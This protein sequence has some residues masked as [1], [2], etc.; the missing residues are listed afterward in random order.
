MTDSLGLNRETGGTITDWEHVVQSIRDLFSTP[1][2]TRV[3]R[4][5]YGSMIPYLI[6]RPGTQERVLDVAVAA[7]EALILWEP[8]FR[9]TRMGIEE[10][11]ADGKFALLVEGIFFPRGH[12]GDYS[13]AEAASGRIDL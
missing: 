8:R 5:D 12:Y 13:Y 7:A 6:D 1:K 3:M 9:L 2:G 4:R 10:G 11:G